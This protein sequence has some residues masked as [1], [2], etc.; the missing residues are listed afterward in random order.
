MSSAEYKEALEFRRNFHDDLKIN[1]MQE[2]VDGFYVRSF[3]K[4]RTDILGVTE[5]ATLPFECHL[6]DDESKR[7]YKFL[8][9][10]IDFED[11]NFIIRGKFDFIDSKYLKEIKFENPN[12]VDEIFNSTTHKHFLK[13]IRLEREYRQERE[14]ILSQL[15]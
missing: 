11:G 4:Y 5:Y 2:L 7:T 1:K 9:G 6:T 3:G 15:K 12:E 13:R 8:E 14:N 10:E